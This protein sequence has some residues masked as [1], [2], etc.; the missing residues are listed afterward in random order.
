MRRR[1]RR[2]S[3]DAAVN[4]FAISGLSKYLAEY[5]VAMM[6]VTYVGLVKVNAKHHPH[7]G[8]VAYGFT[9]VQPDRA[10]FCV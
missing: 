1:R 4:T 3:C 7:A 8:V 5:L 9:D 2:K 6:L 10:R